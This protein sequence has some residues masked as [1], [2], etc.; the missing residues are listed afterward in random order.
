[1]LPQIAKATSVPLLW[2]KEI[3]DL[4]ASVFVQSQ[5]A[6]RVLTHLATCLRLMWKREADGYRLYRPTALTRKDEHH[7]R[8]EEEARTQRVEEQRQLNEFTAALLRQNHL[9]DDE[10]KKI[11]AKFPHVAKTL[12]EQ[13]WFVVG[14]RVATWLTPQQWDKALERRLEFNYGEWTQTGPDSNLP[15]PTLPPKMMEFFESSWRQSGKGHGPVAIQKQAGGSGIDS[16]WVSVQPD[17]RLSVSVQYVVS[18]DFRYGK[19][20]ILGSVRERK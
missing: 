15:T 18:G 10:V 3:A 9:T 16:I 6:F 7:R 8:T 5:P 12:E 19:Q 2:D 11:A 20:F 14:L 4:R 1:M 17:G 13:P